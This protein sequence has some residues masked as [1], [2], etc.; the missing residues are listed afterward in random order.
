ML[1]ITLNG[2]TDANK[3]FYQLSRMGPTLLSRNTTDEIG[4]AHQDIL[5]MR[6]CWP[7]GTSGPIKGHWSGHLSNCT[8]PIGEHR[9][10]NF[11]EHRTHWKSLAEYFTGNIGP[12]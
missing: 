11:K 4:W 9:Y 7:T 10:Y 3:K 8:G 6:S 2:P 12:I 1:P 5:P